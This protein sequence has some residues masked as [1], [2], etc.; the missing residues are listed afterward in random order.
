L[1]ETRAVIWAETA[2]QSLPSSLPIENPA[3]ILNSGNGFRTRTV[4]V[5]ALGLLGTKRN[6]VQTGIREALAIQSSVSSPW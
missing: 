4:Y 2:R 3:G 5:G 1:I 6:T